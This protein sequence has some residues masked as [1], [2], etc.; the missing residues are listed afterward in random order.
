[1]RRP[2][3][4]VPTRIDPGVPNFYLRRYYT[5]ALY[6]AGAAPLLLPLIPTPE[7]IDD[8]VAHVDGI[9]LS[10]S[11]SDL[12]PQ[13]YG[14]EPHPSLGHVI[15]ERDA[16]DQ[17]LLRSAAERNLPV[18]AICYGIQALNV[19]RGGTLYQDILSQVKD[20]IQHEQGEPYEPLT[21]AIS[22]EEKSL[23]AELA[24][25][26][27]PRVNSHHHQAIDRVG[28]GLRPIAWAS[29]GVIEAVT[30]EA[31]DQWML[32][33]QWH[34][35]ASIAIDDFSRAIFDH[36]VREVVATILIPAR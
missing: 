16:V 31:S 32:G 18:L 21:H 19:Y 22:V 10:G 27:D 15:P 30:N 13:R 35:E 3:I 25:R 14:Q 28:R 36:F 33:V 17:L 1:M 23:L 34:P 11:N 6:S 24:G 12:D 9:V 5:D 7:Y 26:T 4:C 20:P 2:L 8:L 29:D